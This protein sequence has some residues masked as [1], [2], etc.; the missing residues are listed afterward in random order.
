MKHVM[1]HLSMKCLVQPTE[2]KMHIDAMYE[3][4]ME[5]MKNGKT[6]HNREQNQDTSLSD[7]TTLIMLLNI[8]CG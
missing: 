5:N 3:G 1:F 8:A 7:G 4:I 6:C 2:R